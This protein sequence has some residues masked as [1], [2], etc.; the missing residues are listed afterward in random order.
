MASVT[1]WHVFVYVNVSL[2]KKY[3]LNVTA[4]AID[5]ARTYGNFKKKKLCDASLMY[6]YLMSIFKANIFLPSVRSNEELALFSL[7]NITLIF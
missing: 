4:I 2:T 7:N 6:M 3:I 5:Y 1:Y